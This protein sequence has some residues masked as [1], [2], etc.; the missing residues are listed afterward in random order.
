M[1]KKE[2]L[3]TFGGNVN[4]YSHCGKQYG[5]PQKLKNR[6]TLWS[7]NSTTGY[8]P[9]EYKNTNSKGYT[10]TPVYSSIIYNSQDMEAAQVSIDKWMNIKDVVYKY[11]GILLSHKK[12]WNLAI[13]NDMHGTR[14]YN[15]KWKKRRNT[16][17][18]RFHSHVEF[19]KQNKWEKRE[20]NER[21]K[22]RNRLLIIENNLMITRVDCS[23]GM[24]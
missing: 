15:A 17:T 14:E 10:R 22:A 9:K 11:N 6:A 16:N 4:W 12:E 5:V 23:G 7:S 3:C 8:L 21:E 24:G 19:K 1:E 20:K 2:H 18:I 13:C